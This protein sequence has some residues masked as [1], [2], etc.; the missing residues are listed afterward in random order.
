M[1]SINLYCYYRNKFRET[2]EFNP[3]T[4][5]TE[6]VVQSSRKKRSDSCSNSSNERAP[7]IILPEASHVFY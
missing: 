6:T 4:T 1:I 7:V 2:N 5:D 3:H